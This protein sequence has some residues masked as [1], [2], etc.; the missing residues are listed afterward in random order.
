[1]RRIIAAHSELAARYLMS[2]QRDDGSWQ[3]YD[4][5]VGPSN[6]WITAVV[7]LSLAERGGEDNTQAASRAAQWLLD[8]RYEEG[9]GFNETTGP[10]V[11][12][13]AHALLLFHALDLPAPASAQDWLRARWQKEGGFATYDQ[14]DAWGNAHVCVTA[15]AYSAVYRSSPEQRPPGLLEFLIDHR[16]PTGDWPAYWWRSNHY[17]HY[18]VLRLLGELDEPLFPVSPKRDYDFTSALDLACIVGIEAALGCEPDAW[19]PMLK[20]LLSHQQNDGAWPP[21]KDLRV[22]NADVVA[23]WSDPEA[24]GEYYEDTGAL[25]TT[26]ICLRVL[27]GL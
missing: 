19:E 20:A 2:Q 13:T 14:D 5:P 3:D 1:L 4:L 16:L 23:P 6:Q 17:A 9:W 26:A 8:N 11:D 21:G 12:S 10:D 25:L 18:F 7:G 22:T 27:C 15:I 24:S